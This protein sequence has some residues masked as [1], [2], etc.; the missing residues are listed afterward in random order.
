MVEPQPRQQRCRELH[1]E[2]KKLDYFVSINCARNEDK[3]KEECI[4]AQYLL[5][6]TRLDYLRQCESK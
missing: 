3:E 5:W 4:K 1:N 6:M 2:L